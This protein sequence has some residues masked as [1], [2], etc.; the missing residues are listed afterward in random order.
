ML[1]EGG[2]GNAVTARS[3]SSLEPPERRR[4]VAR[5]L[6]WVLFAWIIVLGAYFADPVGSHST[7]GTVIRLCVDVL[8]VV[9]VIFWQTRRTV[10]AEYPEIRAMES[11]GVILVIFLALFAALY[12]GMS[13]SAPKSFTQPLDHMTALYFTVTVFSTVGFGDI[14][15]T[16]DAGRAVVSIQMLLDLVLIGSVVRLLVTAARSSL[17]Q[18]STD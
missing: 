6:T 15:P 7:A 4:A 16:M 2:S 14:T 12:L 10:R 13:D 17:K 9:A 18:G 11:L 8:L 3:I 5:M 1:G